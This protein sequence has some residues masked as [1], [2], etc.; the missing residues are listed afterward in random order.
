MSKDT[1]NTNLGTAQTIRE[2]LRDTQ[3]PCT[4][5][6]EA[7]NMHKRPVMALKMACRGGIGHKWTQQNRGQA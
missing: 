7:Q 1:T 3:R 2:A 5:G 4:M 6:T